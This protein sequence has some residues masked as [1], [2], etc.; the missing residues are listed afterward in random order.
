MQGSNLG[1]LIGPP[2]TAGLV[3]AGGWPAA[4][5]LTSLAM[6]VVIGAALFLHWRERRRVQG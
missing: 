3:S 5:W 4:A 6:T 1:S 2:L